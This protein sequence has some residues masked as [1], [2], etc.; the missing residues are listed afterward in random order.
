M[1]IEF[2]YY[3]LDDIVDARAKTAAGDDAAFKFGW[4]EIDFSPGT[5]HVKVGRDLT[6]LKIRLYVLNLVLIED[7]V[8]LVN[9]TGIDNG[10][11]NTALPQSLD[12]EIVTI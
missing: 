4:V 2:H 1:I 12:M 9:K 10:S 11:V 8:V 3:G 5:G 7:M 6:C